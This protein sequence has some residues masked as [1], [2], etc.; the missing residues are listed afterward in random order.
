MNLVVILGF[1]VSLLEG[2]G[3]LCRLNESGDVFSSGFSALG[4]QFF[5]EAVVFSLLTNINAC[6]VPSSKEEL[7]LYPLG[8]ERIV[9]SSH[10]I[11]V[12]IPLEIEN[13]PEL[14]GG[15]LHLLLGL[16]HSQVVS[17]D[18]LKLLL[19]LSLSSLGFRELEQVQLSQST[20]LH[21]T[22]LLLPHLELLFFSLF[23]FTQTLFL[24]P[25]S[26]LLALLSFTL[27]L[28]FALDFLLKQEI[29]SPLGGFLGLLLL[30]VLLALSLLLRVLFA[31]RSR[32]EAHLGSL[33]P[34]RSFVRHHLLDGEWI[35]AITSM[36]LGIALVGARPTLSVLSA[37]PFWML[38]VTAAASLGS[39]CRDRVKI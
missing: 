19:G 28:A 17:L 4:D 3:L 18:Q 39:S 22:V 13:V 11:V 20:C 9:V 7:R 15:L 10:C 6:T 24:S 21:Q 38:R 2:D 35:L 31:V 14:F 36:P 26:L 16:L 25:L 30:F 27:P 1:Q 32:D 37:H 34:S 33:L 23:A 8:V 5:V 12:S 29:L